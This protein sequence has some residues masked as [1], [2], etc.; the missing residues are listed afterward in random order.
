MTTVA[1]AYGRGRLEIDVPD[2]AVVLEP[3]YVPTSEDPVAALQSALRAPLGTRPLREVIHRG[4][5]VTVVH[6]D[7][8]RPMPNDAV[9]NVIW[10][11]CQDLVKQEDFTLLAAL[12]T[13]LINT[14]DELTS[15]LGRGAMRFPHE[16]AQAS[17]KENKVK[18]GTL[19]AGV[20]I[21]VDRR[22]VEANV[23]IL[24]GFVEPHLYAGFSGGPK[25]IVPGIASLENVFY[26]HSAGMISHRQATWGI[27]KGNPVYESILEAAKLLPPTFIVDV[28]LNSDK[29]ITGV[30]AG[31]L[32]IAHS[33]AIKWVKERAMR[34]VEHRF[35]VVVTTNSGYPLDQNLYQS[36]KGLSAAAQ[37]VK[38]GGTILMCSACQQGL[39]NSSNFEHLLRRAGSPEEFS[40]KLHS[41]GFHVQDQ[42]AVQV[43]VEIVKKAKVK[44]Y[45]NGLS[46]E[47]IRMAW[48]EPIQ[49][50]QKALEDAFAEH[51]PK[52]SL[53]LLPEGPQV[54]P[55]VVA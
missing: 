28:A 17:D 45:S 19:R 49:N 31:E 18:I 21:Y 41:P 40:K 8:T 52:A 9:I 35:D 36:V 11:E 48:M 16:Q 2:R 4:D 3:V 5:R 53:C 44:I 27:T 43:I 10:D 38:P 29:Q 47:Q 51:G 55:T 30:F 25:L 14:E 54:I 22:Y 12:G 20:P 39:P 33:T 7:I 46:D 13:H 37:I 23:R 15:I 1:L 34:D 32:E 26:V 6:P 42:W 24:T 50:L